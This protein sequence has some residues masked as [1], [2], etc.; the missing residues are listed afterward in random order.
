MAGKITKE[1]WIEYCQSI[2]ENVMEANKD[3]FLRMK[4]RGD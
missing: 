3:V 1:E 4:K 2:L